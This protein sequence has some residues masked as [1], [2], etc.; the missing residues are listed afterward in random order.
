MDTTQ[1]ILTRLLLKKII[2]LSVVFSSLIVYA[3]KD[4]L[5]LSNGNIMIG[6]IKSMEKSVL[7][8]KTPYSEKDFKIKWYEV[9]EIFSTRY[10][11]ISLENGKRFSST[12]NS[13]PDKKGIV[14]LDAGMSSFEEELKNVIYLDPI[15]KSYLSRLTLDIDVGLTITKSNNYR[16][17]TTNL[18]GIYA[19]DKWNSSA[20][21]NS[22]MTMQDGI[23]DLRR[24]EGNIDFM[25]YLPNLWFLQTEAEFLGNDEQKLDMRSTYKAGGGYFFKRN[26]DLHFGAGMG[27]AYNFETYTDDT[28]DKSSSE[29]YAGVGFNKFD[30]GDISFISNL[31]YYYSLTEASRYR[32]DLSADLKYDLPHDFYIKANLTY[33]FDS[34]PIEG[35]SKDD[36]I[37]QLSFGWEFN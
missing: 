36:Y 7:T 33:N 10:F 30:I 16:Q 37:T 21:F 24:V 29:I 8:Y 2:F 23:E 27:V 22:V 28:P 4:S 31:V 3:Q 20:Y 34:Q 14:Y 12:I 26:N 25:Y 13:V 19:A 6:E 17:F 32:V 5:I 1:L 15:G 18:S 11:I 9:K 35:A